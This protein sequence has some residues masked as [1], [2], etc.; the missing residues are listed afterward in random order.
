MTATVVVAYRPGRSHYPRYLSLL[1]GK[2]LSVDNV[3][4]LGLTI[5]EAL[6]V[7]INGAARPMLAFVRD[8]FPGADRLHALRV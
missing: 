5:T 3:E 2:A 1:P 4:V 7:S 8:P 6:I